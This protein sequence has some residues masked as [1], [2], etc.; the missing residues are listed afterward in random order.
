MIHP[1]SGN[2]NNGREQNAIDG[3]EAADRLMPP[4]KGRLKA[5]NK[6]DGIEMTTCGRVD[7][8]FGTARAKAEG[9]FWL[10]YTGLLM[11]DPFDFLLILIVF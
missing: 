1:T 11:G 10:I 9:F 5:G 8:S 3:F 2:R 7:A 6:D 4:G